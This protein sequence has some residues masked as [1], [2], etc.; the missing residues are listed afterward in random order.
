MRV[1]MCVQARAFHPVSTPLPSSVWAF[2]SCCCPLK[3]PRSAQGCILPHRLS[4]WNPLGCFSRSS[5]PVLSLTPAS[6]AGGRVC[7][8][9]GLAATTRPTREALAQDPCRPGDSG[10]TV[11]SLP[12][13]ERLHTGFRGHAPGHIQQLEGTSA[14]PVQPVATVPLAWS[15]FGASG[16]PSSEEANRTFLPWRWVGGAH[17]LHS[18]PQCHGS[19]FQATML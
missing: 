17:S 7:P 12:A 15:V 2:L 16:Q 19:G 4:P 10:T 11:P 3:V 6:V 14:S 5:D 9:R 1:R 13:T 8:H 18:R